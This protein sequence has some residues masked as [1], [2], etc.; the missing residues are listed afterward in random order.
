MAAAAEA[1][2]EKSGTERERE[3]GRKDAEEGI[4]L[5]NGKRFIHSFLVCLFPFFPLFL[6]YGATPLFLGE[7]TS[8]L[9]LQNVKIFLF[10]PNILKELNNQY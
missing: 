8:R 7:A 9:F 3:R 6:V 5:Q 10:N 2:D 1:R 4:F